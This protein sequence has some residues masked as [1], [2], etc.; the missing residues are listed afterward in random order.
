[1]CII[2]SADSTTTWDFC[3]PGPVI[4]VRP[5]RCK[6]KESFN[7]SEEKIHTAT[8]G[9]EIIKTSSGKSAPLPQPPPPPNKPNCSFSTFL[10][11]FLVR[12][13][14]S[15]SDMSGNRDGINNSIYLPCQPVQESTSTF[16]VRIGKVVNYHLTYLRL[17]LFLQ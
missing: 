11:S 7:S 5:T 14:V 16:L 8:K 9:A 17:P 13:V 2:A 4:Q 12:W 15:S 10:P 1:M 3:D 6:K